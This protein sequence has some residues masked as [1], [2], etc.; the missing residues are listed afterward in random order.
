MWIKNLLQKRKK[1]N[2]EEVKEKVN[3]RTVLESFSLFPVKEIGKLHFT[4]RS[5]GKKKYR[6][7]RLILSKIK[8]LILEQ[9]KVM[10]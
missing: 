2:C 7:F 6:V 1:M 3:I 8:R 10:T 5:T 4:L 9:G